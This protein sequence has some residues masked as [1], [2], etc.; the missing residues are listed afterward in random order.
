MLTPLRLKASVFP[1]QPDVEVTFD[2]GY[3]LALSARSKA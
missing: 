1:E 2:F 3:S